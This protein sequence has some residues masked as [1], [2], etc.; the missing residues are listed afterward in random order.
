MTALGLVP[1][2]P[3]FAFHA[4]FGIWTQ[5]AVETSTVSFWYLQALWHLKPR[6]FSRSIS[7]RIDNISMSFAL[8]SYGTISTIPAVSQPNHLDRSG[9]F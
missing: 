9:L 2:I 6:R 8:F 3:A 5:D 7:P 4:V 1:F